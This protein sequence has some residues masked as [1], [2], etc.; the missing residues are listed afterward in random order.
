MSD[1]LPVWKGRL[2][3]R[4][5]HLTLIKTALFAIPLDTTISV[6]LH[7][8]LIRGMNKLMKGFLL[9]GTEVAQ[10]GKSLVTWRKVQRPLE[11]GSCHY[12]TR[13]LLVPGYNWRA[14]HSNVSAVSSPALTPGRSLHAAE[15]A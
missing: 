15:H 7:P 14:N 12:S 4:T 1:K 9:P 3:N 8:W 6:E 10:K 2:M 13:P 11:L 5:G